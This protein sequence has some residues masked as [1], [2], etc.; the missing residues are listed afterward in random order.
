MRVYSIRNEYGVKLVGVE[1]IGE[2]MAGRMPRWVAC[3][4]GV[5]FASSAPIFAQGDAWVPSA[6]LP[7]PRRL[8]AAAAVAGKVYTFGGCG[9]PCFQPPLHTSTFEERRVEVYDPR[10]NSWS[11]AGRMPSIFFGGAAAAPGDGKVYLFGGFVTGHETWGYDPQRDTWS[12]KKDMPFSRHGLAAV[13]LGG[14][15]YVLGGSSGSAALGGLEVYDPATDSWSPRAPLPTPRVFLGAAVLDG[16]V[17]AIGGSPDCC[18]QGAT[19]IVEIYDPATNT[20]RPGRPLPRALQV[21]AA[22]SVNG[23]IY[24]AGGFIPG[25]GVQGSTFEYDLVADR[26]TEKAPLTVPRDQA[27][28]VAV[29]DGIHLLG[30]SKDCHCQAL[31]DHERYVPLTADLRIEKDDGFSE[32]CP[33]QALSYA[34]TVTNA[35]P[36]AVS[37]A[38]VSDVVSPLLTGATWTCRP[39]AGA[40]CGSEGPRPPPIDDRVVLPAGGRVTYTLTGTLDLGATGT[41]A[42]TATVELPGGVTDPDPTN[43]SATDSDVVRRGRLF[44]TKTDGRDEVHP[45]ETVLYEIT[46][47]HDCP[48]PV[49]VTVEDMLTASGL[50]EVEWCRG[51]GCTPLIAGDLRQTV[52]IAAKGSVTYRAAGTVGDAPCTCGGSPP[53]PLTNQACATAPGLRRWCARDIDSIATKQEADVAVDVVG[54]EDL[55]DCHERY[56]ITVRNQGPCTASGVVLEV[57]PPDGFDLVALSSPCAAGV[58]CH[59][60]N[61]PENFAVQ[62]TATLKAAFG[63]QCAAE[64]ATLKATVESG[65]D[66]R[67]E[68]DGDAVSTSVA[69][70]LA[71]TKSDDLA[72]AAPGDCIRYTIDVANHGCA[73]VAGVPVTDDFPAALESVRWCRGPGCVPVDAS[74]P[75]ADLVDL[76]PGDVASYLVE[77]TVSPFFTGSLS[78]TAS[79]VLPADRTPA[80]NSATDLTEVF[81][82]PG[83]SALC[84]DAPNVAF[85]GE[86]VEFTFVLWNGGAA[87]QGDNPGDEFVNMLPAGLTLVDAAATSGTIATVADTVTWNGAIGVGESVTLMITATVDLGAAGT[88]ICNT[89]TVS[90]DADGD[91]GNESS[92]PAADACEPCCFEVL[93]APAIPV[94]SPAALVALVLLLG[95]LAI[96]RLRRRAGVA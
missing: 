36:S 7:T 33:A 51:A 57:E 22:A 8:L 93:P 19:D 31:D 16:R 4:T 46:T 40:A 92:A 45:G 6:D 44:V 90:F 48:A 86:E 55:G 34:I 25:Q 79:A 74:D 65:C 64:P 21:S 56:T 42:N 80:D 38:R 1:F 53:A 83:V 11:I 2:A 52:V 95:G 54:P 82:P 24:V 43:N 32:V 96:A 61:I 88:T 89:A 59:L 35:G 37:G 66:P 29:A 63:A 68:N 10:L 49:V 47:R 15:V 17:Y 27:P 62:V 76:A 14:K 60:G 73:A 85:E 70:D 67:I 26:W 41:L 13:A 78:N 69:C 84:A 20:W 50:E 9:S 3:L 28:A 5:V 81:P 72:T 75:L 23:R 18:A 30:G 91:G 87:A 58:P 12:R 77:S 94:L 71:V 39:A